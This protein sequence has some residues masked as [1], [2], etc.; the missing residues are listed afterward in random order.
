M[1]GI[2]GIL[3]FGG[4]ADNTKDIIDRMA[5]TMNHRGPDARGVWT[6]GPVGLAHTRLSIIDIEGGKQ[7]MLTADGKSAVTFN[8]EIFNHV[9]L[10][11][12]LESLG[13]RFASNHSDTEVILIAYR[14][15][16]EACVERFNGQWAFALWDDERQRM[17]L[18]RDRLGIR[19]L[20]YTWCGSTFLFGSEIKSIFAYP[21]MTRGLNYPALADL[22]TFWAP[23]PGETVFDQCYE[24]EPGHSFIINK[25]GIKK[26][27]YWQFDF[28]PEEDGRRNAHDW[29][30][31]LRELLI[32][33]T[34]LRLR[35]DVPVGAYLSGGLDSSVNVSL[36]K[37]FTDTKVCTF[38][39]TFAEQEFD[40][41]SYQQDVIRQLATEHLQI[42]CQ[43]RDIGRIFPD[44]IWHTE[45]P[46]FR[47]APAPFFLL[48]KLVRDNNYKVVLTGEGA[49][50]MLGGYDIFK[51]AKVRHFWGRYPDSKLRPLLLKKLYPYMKNLQAQ[52]PDYLKAFFQIS[53]E[54]LKSPLFSHLPRF[55]LTKKTHLFFSP[56]VKAAIG[57]RDAYR[58]LIS[59]LPLRFSGYS[60]FEKAQYLETA[61]LLP[62]YILS[63]QGDRMTMANSVEG[64]FPFLDHRVAELQGRIPA[65][66]KM[67]VLDEKH[68][69]K[70]ATKDLIPESVIRRPK[71]PYRAPD[72]KSFF[73]SESPRT[74]DY[75]DELLSEKRV[76]QN[77]VFNSKAVG[78]LVRKAK[79]GK[80]IG[81]KDNMAL[82]GVLSTHVLIDKFIDNF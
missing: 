5:Q 59:L 2:T 39:V 25:D 26:W 47:T 45:K 82:V 53:P 38:S 57:R 52:S 18:S 65:K 75:V 58:E 12:E 81:V 29:A 24:L 67:S 20:Y 68:V 23:L 37:H 11:S 73:Y 41:S 28:C 60:P 50:E 30:E 35:A 4:L 42:H 1:C 14:Q 48:S 8:G 34:R 36:I 66:F 22:L 15:W 44:V 27:R 49:D 76:A 51:E 3:N 13:H 61:L 31:E 71:Q 6:K 70:L 62:G 17:F 33:A 63:S 77:G 55:E 21:E 7:P 72:A 43:N 40:E 79:D 74:P 19:P 64:R 78:Q 69:L 10:R 32:D 54:L 16:G 56:E 46:V 9:E 80:L